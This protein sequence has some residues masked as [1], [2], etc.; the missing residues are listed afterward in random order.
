MAAAVEEGAIGDDHIDAV[1]KALDV[2]PSAVS[3]EKK[4]KSERNLVRHAKSQ[5]AK[6]VKKIGRR[7]ADHLNPDGFFDDNDRARRRG[8]TLGP[9]QPME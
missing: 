1:C 2:L 5:D 4:E 3:R 7:I 8:L 9:Q 6:F